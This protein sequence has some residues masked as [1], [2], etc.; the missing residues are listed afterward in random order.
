[1][2]EIVEKKSTK[3]IAVDSASDDDNGN[4]NVSNTTACTHHTPYDTLPPHD[5]KPICTSSNP[6]RIRLTV[7]SASRCRV[8]SKAKSLPIL[9]RGKLPIE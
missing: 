7:C 4:D 5:T 8:T 6:S 9:T 2:N 3:A 1:M